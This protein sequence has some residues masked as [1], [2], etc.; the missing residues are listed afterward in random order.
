M[1]TNSFKW[2]QA[3]SAQE[4]A[5]EATA[6][7]AEL[8]FKKKD[9]QKKLGSKPASIIK[10]GGIDVLDL[11]KEDL[12]PASCLVNI[13]NI[14][15]LN[16]IKIATDKSVI[17]GPLCTL[18]EIAN[19]KELRANFVALTDAASHIATPNI[20]NVATVGG[21]LL[22]R[23]RCWY[24]RSADFHCLKKGGEH[25]FS[26]DGENKYH[27]IFDTDVCSSAHA[28]TMAVPLIAF[29]ASLEILSANGK[30][31]KLLLEEFF[32][33]PAI[34]VSRENILA[35]NELI[36]A[37]HIP[38]SG[39]RSAHLKSGE[40]DSFDWS[41]G[42]CAVALKIEKNVCREARIILGAM[43]PV[44]LRAKEAEAFLLGKQLDE[45]TAK[46]AADIAL[47]GAKPLSQNGYKVELGKVIVERTIMKAAS[48]G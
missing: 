33:G 25:C 27:S 34:D 13:R 1:I 24:F 46:Q 17:L 26:I 5:R 19:H 30:T 23:P 10:A 21:N 47:K 37:I 3:N 18:N 44:P 45:S 38:F 32:I 28:S 15:G 7:T 39:L 2:M 6:T 22:Q 36:T 48:N 14:A 43:A 20:R 9:D 11:L 12:L 29:G 42:D 40:K 35:A 41:T 16:G 31:K 8:C 4:A